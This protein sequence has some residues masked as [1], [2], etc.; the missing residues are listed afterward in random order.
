MKCCMFLPLPIVCITLGDLRGSC[1]DNLPLVFIVIF[2][3][4]E[5][6]SGFLCFVYY[7]DR[8]IDID[9]QIIFVKSHD[10]IM[11]I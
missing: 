11:K 9:C 10:L 4:L 2:L 7:E 5:G 1:A 3:S 8:A 6:T